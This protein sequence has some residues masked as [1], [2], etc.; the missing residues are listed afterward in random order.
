MSKQF[1]LNLV[2]E[3]AVYRDM[4]PLVLPPSCRRVV[5]LAAVKR[6]ELHRS[7]VCATLWPYSPPAKAVASLR[8]ALWRLRPLGADPLLVVNRHHLGLAPHV[9]V[10]WHEVLH[11]AGRMSPDSDPRLRRLLGDGDLLDGWTEPWCVTERARFR[12]LKQAALASPAIRHPNCGA[13]P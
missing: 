8:S 2:G 13:M 6:R 5:A 7:W 10:D 11:L 1:A 9:W 12:A 4:K 3:F